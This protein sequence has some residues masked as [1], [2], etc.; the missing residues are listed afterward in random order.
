MEQSVRSFGAL[1]ISDPSHLVFG[2]APK[3]VS[4]GYELT[5]GAGYVYPEVNFTLP[6]ITVCAENWSEI[7]SQYTEMVTSIIRRAVALRAP[8]I[9]L[10]FELLPAMT[11]CPEWGAEITALLHR[12]LQEAHGKHGLRCALRVTPTDIREQGKPPLLRCGPGC[13][14]LLYSFEQCARAGADILSIESIGG[15]EVHDQALLYG[16]VPGIV[17]ALGVLAPRDMSWLWRQIAEICEEHPPIV[18]GGD[19]ACAFANT[20]MQLAHQRMLPEVLAAVVRA[21]SAVRSLV[22]FEQGA[23]GP[24]KDCAY[25]GP[26]LKSIAGC[27]ISMEGRSATCA[28]F[29]PV[30]NVASAMCDLWSN[31]SVQNVRLLSGSAPEAYT[32]SLIYDC[33]LMN[34]AAEQG[35][36]LMLRDWLTASDRWLSP[37]AAVLSPQATLEI[38][39]AIV[40]ADGHYAK[41]IAAGRAA[42]SI[43]RGGLSTGAMQISAKE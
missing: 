17:F 1:A 32:E 16:D 18:A 22:A 31:E 2:R 6:A 43:L 42:V 26:I 9:V 35:G 15:K 33:R 25:E 19:S 10:E 34:V 11:E 24:S 41:T 37:Q 28:H 27:P 40:R 8:G 7:V 3:P 14:K 39:A 13:E 23:I 5:I 12:A 29:S 38:A 36:A 30:G 21:M 4:C 20:A